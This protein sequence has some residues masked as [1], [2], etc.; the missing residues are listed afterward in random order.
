MK[1]ARKVPKLE[2]CKAVLFA[3]VEWA[4]AEEGIQSLGNF[5]ARRACASP[6]ERSPCQTVA[7]P[8]TADMAP[9]P[10]PSYIPGAHPLAYRSDPALRFCLHLYSPTHVPKPQSGTRAQSSA[11]HTPSTPLFSL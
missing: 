4:E 11:S 3:E 10:Q 7:A 8:W 5:R 1:M 2:N 9:G 6:R